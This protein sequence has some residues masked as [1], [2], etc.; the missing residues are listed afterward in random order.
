MNQSRSERH[1][2]VNMG[3]G[4]YPPKFDE[5]GPWRMLCKEA[6][7]VVT[8]SLM[9]NIDGVKSARQTRRSKH[10]QPGLEERTPLP[11]GG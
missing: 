6:N 8:T 3:K 5:R 4:R 2:A 9:H 1:Q 10:G 11:R 7:V